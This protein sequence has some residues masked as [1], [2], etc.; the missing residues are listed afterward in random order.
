MKRD[1]SEECLLVLQHGIPPK[2]GDKGR[3]TVPCYLQD[4]QI[5]NALVDLGASVNLMPYSL[6]RK[7]GLIDLNPTRMTIQLADR[8][9]K[10]PRGITEDVLVRVDKFAFPVDFIIMD[11]EEEEKVPLILGRPFLNN[12]KVVIDVHEK[13]LKLR[14]GSE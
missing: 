9:V 2:L 4:V 13:S 1:I 12:A 14:V 7:L 10:L 8:S 6:F 3:F 11:I 5:R